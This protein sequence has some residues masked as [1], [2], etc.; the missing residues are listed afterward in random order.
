MDISVNTL[1]KSA[2]RFFTRSEATFVLDPPQ[3]ML[4]PIEEKHI[5]DE[6]HF[7]DL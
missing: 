2:F 7:Y 3:I 6:E 1:V 4:G 5:L